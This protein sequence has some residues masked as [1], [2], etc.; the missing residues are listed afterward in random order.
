MDEEEILKQLS[1][2]KG[3]IIGLIIS[4]PIILFIFFYYFEI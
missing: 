1:I 2:I 4:I 3:L